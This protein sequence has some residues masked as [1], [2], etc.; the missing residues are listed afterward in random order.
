[1]VSL[2]PKKV[3]SITQCSYQEMSCRVVRGGQL[4][5]NFDFK[6]GVS[7]GCLLWPF[8][9]TPV[10]DWTMR[11]STEGRSNG[12]QWTLWSQLD[13]L[14]FADDL[15]LLSHSHAHM[16]DK[17][18]CLVSASAKIGLHNHIDKKNIMRMHHASNNPF[19]VAR[20]PP[21]E[22][23]SFSSVGSIIDTQGGIDAYV[24]VCLFAGCLTSQ[25]HARL[26][27]GQICSDNFYVLPNWDRSC[28]SNFL[29]HPVTVYW[30]RVDQSQR[31]PYNARR[32]ARQPLECQFLSH[33][34]DLTQKKSQR[35]R[36]SNPGSSALEADALPLGQRGGCM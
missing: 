26:S 11:T 20:Q 14:E 4:S 28:R 13:D 19:T 29:P 35:K 24:R 3:L 25:Q 32:L 18:T 5:D 22:V 15:T 23:N 30:H 8:L 9:F 7:K 2:F 21:E 12:M 1:M 27:Q 34:Y 16:Q 36:N 33:W 17:T 6:T 10:V 31:W